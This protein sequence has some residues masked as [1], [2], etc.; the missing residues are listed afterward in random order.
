MSIVAT[1][2]FSAHDIEE[3]GG[4]LREYQRSQGEGLARGLQPREPPVTTAGGTALDEPKGSQL[5]VDEMLARR[6]EVGAPV[7]ENISSLDTEWNLP[8]LALIFRPPASLMKSMSVGISPGQWVKLAPGRGSTEK[9]SKWG[10]LRSAMQTGIAFKVVAREGEMSTEEEANLRRQR[11]QM[12]VESFK[13]FLLNITRAWDELMASEIADDLPCANGSRSVSPAEVTHG[14]PYG[15]TALTSR[16]LHTQQSLHMRPTAGEQQLHMRAACP[17][18]P[19]QH[20]SFPGGAID[21]SSRPG[22]AEDASAAYGTIVNGTIAMHPHAAM[23]V[24][25]S[26]GGVG[27]PA[28]LSHLPIA[29]GGLRAA[30]LDSGAWV[31]PASGGLPVRGGALESWHSHAEGPGVCLWDASAGGGFSGG[32]GPVGGGLDVAAFLPLVQRDPFVVKAIA[33]GLCRLFPHFKSTEE[34]LLDVQLLARSLPMPW[35]PSS[36]SWQIIEVCCRMR[37]RDAALRSRKAC[38]EEYLC[39]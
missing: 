14:A 20:A 6:E 16:P 37:V 17:Y 10:T 30:E 15:A 2:G 3:L 1:Q 23:H 24:H 13:Y 38:A 31:N 22:C 35:T 7:L 29:A 19:A 27:L 25:R 33:T 28:M 9:D 34:A 26:G 12:D 36:S 32:M 39:E 18:I 11:A 21:A 5:N 4:R 8:D